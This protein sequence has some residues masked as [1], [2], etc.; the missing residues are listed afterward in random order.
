MAIV[1]SVSTIGPGFGSDSITQRTGIIVT[2]GTT[3]SIPSTGSVNLNPIYRGRMRVKIYN[4]T[5]TTPTVT[6]I[7]ASIT[8]GVNTVLIGEFAPTSAAAINAT[9]WVDTL[10][11]FL[12]D[13]STLGGGATG[14]LLGPGTAVAIVGQ[15]VPT[16]GGTG[17]GCTMD[18][19]IA[20]AP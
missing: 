20:G 3:Y 6:N 13:Y 11:E 4:G 5:G 17:P 15:I 7:Q 1:N 10:F 19:E 9:N 8:D 12:L 14:T 18:I 2:S 16:L